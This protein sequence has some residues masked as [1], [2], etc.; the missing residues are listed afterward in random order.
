[1]E[2]LFRQ[3]PKNLKRRKMRNLKRLAFEILILQTRYGKKHISIHENG[4]WVLIHNF[5]LPKY[6]YNMD[7]CRVLIFIPPNYD[8]AEITWC[9]IDEKLK[10]K[11][12]IFGKALPHTFKDKKLTFKGELLL[13]I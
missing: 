8:N 1:M 7:K 9:H 13:A 10:W 4:D 2:L 11:N 6:K 3:A 5:K 12:G